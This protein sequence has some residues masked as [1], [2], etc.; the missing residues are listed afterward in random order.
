M[1]SSSSSENGYTS[2]IGSFLGEK[3]E[4]GEVERDGREEREVVAELVELVEELSVES[5]DP[6][7]KVFELVLLLT[8]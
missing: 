5:K 3:R 8:L 4:N 1:Y 2:I 7:L 6:S